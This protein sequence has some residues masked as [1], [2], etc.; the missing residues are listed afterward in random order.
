MTSSTL[1][2]ALEQ[3]KSAYY[4]SLIGPIPCKI[5]SITSTEPQDLRP[6][7]RQQ[8]T[9]TVTKEVRGYKKGAKLTGW[10]LD[11]FPRAAL[12]RTRYCSYIKPYQVQA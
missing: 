12:R 4:D 5:D 11:F 10:G 1:L 9:A 8:V 7:S 6:S 3:S 2:P